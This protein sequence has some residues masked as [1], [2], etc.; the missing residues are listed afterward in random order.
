MNKVEDLIK[1]FNETSSNN[2]KKVK[3]RVQT[4]KSKKE[5]K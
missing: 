1:K 4:H 5:K 2:D 3:K